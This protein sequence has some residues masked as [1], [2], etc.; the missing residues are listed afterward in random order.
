MLLLRY[1]ASENAIRAARVYELTAEGVDAGGVG[2][3]PRVKLHESGLCRFIWLS[4]RC[5]V[6]G[7]LFV[8]SLLDDGLAEYVDV[9][10]TS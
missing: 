8:L 2:P 10:S 3:W 7:W 4:V 6:E 1:K 9:G 5:C